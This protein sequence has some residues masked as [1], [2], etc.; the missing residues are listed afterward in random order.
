MSQDCRLRKLPLAR[1]YPY[2]F[3]NV[4][5]N[6]DTYTTMPAILV[7]VNIAETWGIESPLAILWAKGAVVM[8]QNR[9]IPGDYI[10]EIVKAERIE[11][12]TV[13]VNRPGSAGYSLFGERYFIE[14]FGIEIVIATEAGILLDAQFPLKGLGIKAL[15]NLLE[16][17]GM[18]IPPGRVAISLE[19][20]IGLKCAGTV[21]ESMHVVFSPI[22]A[23]INRQRYLM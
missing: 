12:K 11:F 8:G 23:E 19:E 20:L 5:A 18:K 15:R 6:T 3:C 17:C 14:H 4:V 13:R 1:A 16:S 22:E 7:Y 10:F 2:G 21:D 9:L